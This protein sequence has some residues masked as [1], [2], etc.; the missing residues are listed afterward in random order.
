MSSQIDQLSMAMSA[1][2]GELEPAKK[3]SRDLTLLEGM[4]SHYNAI[5]EQGKSL[6]LQE[7]A[8]LITP[9][10]Y[11]EMIKIFTCLLALRTLN[12]IGSML[13]AE[14]KNFR[15]IACESKVSEKEI[16]KFIENII[17]IADESRT[18]LAQD[19]ER[20]MTKHNM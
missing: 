2:Q 7:M 9:D 14:S 8:D 12:L 11:E 5:W 3:N 6:Y 10:K 19:K 13:K 16:R 4:G 17:S 18:Y 20:I 15:E 1:L